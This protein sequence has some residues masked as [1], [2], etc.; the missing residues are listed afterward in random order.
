VS[1]ASEER[2]RRERLA[3]ASTA[4][5]EWD[6]YSD[7]LFAEIARLPMGQAIETMLRF[8]AYVQIAHQ[9]NHS[10]PLRYTNAGLVIAGRDPIPQQRTD[11]R[12][13]ALLDHVRHATSERGR[14]D[15][16]APHRGR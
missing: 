15:Y 12:P 16:R 11:L 3:R 5:A 1:K 13:R 6:R 14:L 9:E 2:R 10:V 7:E 4:D 8:R